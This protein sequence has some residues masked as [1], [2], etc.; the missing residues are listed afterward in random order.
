MTTHDASPRTRKRADAERNI[1]AILEAARIALSRDPDA[2]IGEI[3]KAAGVGRVTL[4]GHFPTR[5]ELVT[6][7]VQRALAEAEESVDR[8]DLTGDP[9]DALHRL[10]AGSWS[11]TADAGALLAAADQ[12]L[13]A[14]D[15]RAAHDGLLARAT[16]LIER[17]RAEGVF[18]TD[19]SSSWLVSVLHSL[20]H[21]AATE[22]AAGRLAEEDAADHI[23]ATALSSFTPPA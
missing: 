8:I 4:Y 16:D 14:E 20:V 15:V 10:I 3:A 9:R 17:G 21:C 6:A 5:A 11:L 23:A 12:A 19:L 13:P 18:R 7:V 22:V 2:S 1:E